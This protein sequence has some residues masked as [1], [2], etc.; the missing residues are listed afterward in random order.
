MRFGMVVR[1]A[2]E[3]YL[4]LEGRIRTFWFCE[5]GKNERKEELRVCLVEFVEARWNNGGGVYDDVAGG[6][7]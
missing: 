2:W 3:R 7:F 5:G 1:G 4:S 6:I